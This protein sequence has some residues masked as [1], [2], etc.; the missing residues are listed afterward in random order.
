MTPSKLRIKDDLFSRL[1]PFQADHR[2]GSSFFHD[3]GDHGEQHRYDGG[4]PVSDVRPVPKEYSSDGDETHEPREIGPAKSPFLFPAHFYKNLFAASASLLKKRQHTATVSPDGDVGGDGSDGGASEVEE[5]AE[6]LSSSQPVDA[7]GPEVAHFSRHVLFAASPSPTYH[8]QQPVGPLAA[9]AKDQKPALPA[10]PGRK[11]DV[12][13][14]EQLLEKTS[15]AFPWLSETTNNNDYTKSNNNHHHGTGSHLHHPHHPHHHHHHHHHPHLSHPHAQGGGSGSQ[16]SLTAAASS[17]AIAAAAAANCR[18]AH[19]EDT[20]CRSVNCGAAQPP[21]PSIAPGLAGPEGATPDSGSTTVAATAA[22]PNFNQMPVPGTVQGQNPTQGLVHWMSAVMAEHMTSNPHHDP[23][24]AAVGMHYMWNGPVEQCG[25]H[26]KDMDSYGG[27]PTPRNH[28]SMKQGY[29]AKMNPV[30][31]HHHHHHHHHNNLQ[32]SHM[33]DDGRLLDHHTMQAG[34]AQMS[35]LYGARGSSSS[36]SPGGHGHGHGASNPAAALLVVPQPINA[37]KIGA[38]TGLP[39]GTGRKY[40]CKMCPQIFTSKADLQ[41]HTQIHMREAKP[42]KCSQCNKAFANSSY[43]SQH[44]RIHLGIKPYRCEICQRKFTQLSHLQQHIRTHTGD[45]PYKCRHSGCLKAFSQL[46]NLQSHSRCHQTDKP[47]KCNSCY[48][49]F[50][51][52]PSLLEHI[53]KH[54]ESKH[55]KT[56]ICQYCG[57][58][59]TQETYLSKHMQKHAERTDKRPPI[60]TRSSSSNANNGGTVNVSAATPGSSSGA[61]S[62]SSNSSHASNAQ[63]SAVAA[64]AAAAMGAESA[65]WP[66]VSPDSAAATINEVISQQQNNHHDFSLTPNGSQTSGSTASAVAGN[67]TTDHQ[68]GSHHA[69]DDA[70]EDL[71]GASAVRGPNDAGA[72]NASNGNSNTGNQQQQQPQSGQQHNGGP[73]NGGNLAMPP[74]STPMSVSYDTSSIAKAAP[75]SAFTPINAIPPHL[76]GLQHHHHQLA[77]S[78]RPSYLYDAINFQN[79]KA[80]AMN[81]SPSNAFPNQLISLHQIRNY[82]HQP[83]GGLMAGEHLL[84]VTVGPGGKDKG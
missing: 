4:G 29:E 40:Q 17:V 19:P 15:N 52:E 3:H 51:D 14:S 33:I 73:L 37:T 84:G 20:K 83:A 50:S 62:S 67:Q 13:H 34:A 16:S 60:G 80:V 28:M 31:H 35:Q 2:C 78:Q 54:K 53:P 65:Y 22:I 41:L 81:Q 42:Y 7:A 58:S 82:A 9:F 49:C 8:H 43:L 12:K 38:T 23:T 69:R 25:Q 6:D 39:N 26:T 44:T 55:L 71:V 5:K 10:M 72:P 36:N 63:P 61:S 48:K 24:A 64:V 47:F 46:S 79:Q 59:Y 77:A 56:H 11:L 66:K 75:N 18:H 57:K 21:S 70:V 68:P 76:G 1:T 27:W 30:D 45:K 74:S 32:K